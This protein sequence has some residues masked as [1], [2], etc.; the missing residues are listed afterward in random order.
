MDGGTVRN[1][2]DFDAALIQLADGE[3]A[4][5]RY[6]TMENPQ[7]SVVRLLQMD[8]VWFPAQRC[9]RDDKTG[10][11]PCRALADGPEPA[12]KAAG[13]TRMI[14]N[15]DPRVNAIAP[16]LVVVTF[17]LPYTLS[18]VAERHYYGTGLIV[19]TELGYVVVDRTTV[20]IAIGDVTITFAGPLEV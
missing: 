11:W 14:R 15:D 7:N 18:G 12:P 20:P 8:R 19:D 4:L 13:S 3:R 2:D 17:D 6:I 5:V 16:S 1:L 9:A 10:L